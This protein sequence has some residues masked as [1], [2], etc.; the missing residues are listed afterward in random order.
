MRSGSGDA[1]AGGD[2]AELDVVA[3]RQL[4]KDVAALRHV[5]D[6]G[7]EQA[8]RRPVGDV[9]A[10][11]PDRALRAGNMPKMV[12]KTVDLPA[13]F[14]PITVVMEPRGTSKVVPLRIVIRP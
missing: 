5:A 8:S 14:G 6:A 3:H 7:F 10:V 1:G 9:L 2:A 12:L 4:G 11:E 13:P